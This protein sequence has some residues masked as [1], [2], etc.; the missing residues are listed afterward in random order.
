MRP[1]GKAVLLWFALAL[2]PFAVHTAEK[3]GSIAWEPW[4]DSVFD[5]AR[6][7]KKFVL[8]DLEAVWCHWCH[9]MDE[10]TYSDPKVIKLIQTHFI[11]LRVDQDS[12]P[13]LSNRYEDYGWPAT[14]VFNAEGGEIVKRQGYIPPEEMTAM[15]EAIIKDPTPGPSVK[16]T[17]PIKYASEGSLSPELR[18][19][20]SDK[21]FSG[22]DSKAGG[23][24]TG[25]QKF[26]EWDS[27]EY[28]M[29]LATAGDYRAERMARQTLAAQKKLVDPIWGGVYQYS[30]DGDWEHPHYEKIMQFQ[31]ENLRIFTIGF[32]LWNDMDYLQAAQD[33][34]GFLKEFLTSPEGAFYTSMDADLVPGRH[35]E[36]Y[37]NLNNAE[38]RKLGLP[39][40]DKNIYSRENGWAITGLA[41][42]YGAIGGDPQLDDAKK[43]A[44]W[45][46]ANRSLPGGGFRHDANDAAGPY[47]GDTLQMCRAFFA[48]YSVTADRNWL[49]RAEKAATF[50]EKNFKDRPGYATSA[51]A[52]A[53]LHRPQPQLDENVQVARLMNRLY[54]STGKKQYRVMAEHAMRYLATPD[55]AL[56]RNFYVGGILLADRELSTP[57]L[58]ITVVGPKNDPMAQALFYAASNYPSTYKRVEWWDKREGPLPNPDVEYPN[59][60]VS[61][62]FICTD[63]ACSAPIF[64]A[65]ELHERI[66]KLLKPKRR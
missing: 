21:F 43:A 19:K 15:L 45:V 52:S 7:E 41:T 57:P 63:K 47:L 34:Y 1:A 27:V 16:P 60:K 28:C 17:K 6:K 65:D 5:R 12:R 31:G 53:G 56:S 59:L 48:L 14:I 44:E 50:I 8:L 42:L 38:R 58:H 46:I 22:Y 37:F 61:A 11:P 66:D 20:L 40:V 10:K 26:L 30:T 2:L 49:N 35:S 51:P 39:R 54:H 32:T 18:K 3:K 9:V 62:A 29:A 13:D 25:G 4:S 64:K 36:G 23:W 33:I 55:V 24:G